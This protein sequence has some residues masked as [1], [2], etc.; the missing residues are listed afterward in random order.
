MIMTNF[1]KNRR[2][3][4][5]FKRKKV[6]A[7]RLEEVKSYL[8]TMEKEECNGN[9][10]FALYENGENLY[11]LLK[12]LGGYS[13]VMIESP[14]YISL[15]LM[16][17]E[18]ESIIYSAYFMEKL[19]SKLNSLGIDTCWISLGHVEKA[20]KD[21]ALGEKKGEVNYLLAIGYPK[22]RNPFV[23]EPV[24]E[25]IGIEEL[26]YSNKVGNP[27]N[28]EE[29]DNRGLSDLFYYVRFA[30]SARNEQPWRFLLEEDKA[31]LLIKN[32]DSLNQ[33][34]MDAGIMMYYFEAL[35][36]SIG[37]NTKWELLGEDFKGE[38]PE[39][40]YIAEIKL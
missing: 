15:E 11:K 26:V 17:Q 37:I 9:I 23:E 38:S 32:V 33:T 8:A 2:S 10:R 19:I 22:P 6:D 27:A 30:P 28:L 16:N 4:R 18:E 35:S 34:L 12:G 25:R 36:S 7:G 1:L 21:K 31:I 24:S 14:H 3:V 13:G 20:D 40:K 39:Y 5:D 29:L